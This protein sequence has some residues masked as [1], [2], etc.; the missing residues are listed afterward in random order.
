M[1]SQVHLPFYILLVQGSGRFSGDELEQA[2]E[3]SKMRR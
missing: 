1:I 3:M 2:H